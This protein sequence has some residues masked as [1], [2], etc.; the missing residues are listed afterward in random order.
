MSTEIDIIN[1]NTTPKQGSGLAAPITPQ[2][3]D[4]STSVAATHYAQFGQGGYRTVKK[5]LDLDNISDARLELGMMVNVINDDNVNNNGLWILDSIDGTKRNWK[6]LSID[7][8]NLNNNAFQYLNWNSKNFPTTADIIA[9]GGDWKSIISPRGWY[10]GAAVEYNFSDDTLTKETTDVYYKLYL[11]SKQYGPQ[12]VIFENSNYIENKTKT[13]EAIFG[14]NLCT[15]LTSKFKLFQLLSMHLYNSYI[16]N[17]LVV[18]INN[19]HIIVKIVNWYDLDYDNNP[20]AKN[21]GG[22]NFKYPFTDVNYSFKGTVV[23]TGYCND[24]DL[25]N[26]T[27]FDAT[28][29]NKINTLFSLESYS[30][31]TYLTSEYISSGDVV[32]GYNNIASGPNNKLG[33]FNAGSFGNGNELFDS[34]PTAFG[35]SNKVH[36]FASS[37]IGQNNKVI[38]E[39]SIAVGTNNTITALYSFVSGNNNKARGYNG[40]LPNNMPLQAGFTVGGSFNNIDLRTSTDRVNYPSNTVFGYGLQSKTPGQTLFGKFNEVNDSIFAIG[41]GTASAAAKRSN[42]FEV[43][44]EGL[45]KAN[46]GLVV[47]DGKLTISKGYLNLVVYKEKSDGT[48]WEIKNP[49]DPQYGEVKL[50]E[51]DDEL[52]LNIT[53]TGRIASLPSNVTV[54]NSIEMQ[55][56]EYDFNTGK[57]TATGNPA[58]LQCVQ[59]GDDTNPQ[60][61]LRIF[62]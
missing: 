49:N 33:A 7:D 4:L 61:S 28:A 12:K 41:N 19:D 62:R 38:G 36:G 55:I 18:G 1:L 2:G 37:A 60:Y 26:K 31:E 21:S 45:T 50:V 5:Y 20:F 9:N 35:R 29:Y 23:I 15:G 42:A 24:K 13:P 8:N 47:S 44:K 17:F 30:P 25:K 43:T 53:D 57:A 32:I 14:N 16:N 3:K 40:F 6:K 59:L 34:F 48:G 58:S 39:K 56:Y 27:S 22:T 54:N 52:V 11:T 10:L 46:G 51:I